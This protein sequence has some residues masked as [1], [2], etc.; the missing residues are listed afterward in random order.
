M[1]EPEALTLSAFFLGK[2]RGAQE[3]TLQPGS[4]WK[5][6]GGALSLSWLRKG[7][8]SE[9]WQSGKAS[10]RRQTWSFQGRMAY[11]LFT[12]ADGRGQRVFHLA[13]GQGQREAVNKCQ[14]PIGIVWSRVWFPV[15]S[16]AV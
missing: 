8:M 13:Y 2:Y 15:C 6:A 16:N 9:L 14:L 3:L 5:K 12:A 7:I 11:T 10:R 1:K 4:S